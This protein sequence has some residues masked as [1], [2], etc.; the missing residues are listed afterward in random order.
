MNGK[1][2]TAR[3]GREQASARFK[4]KLAEQF[5]SADDD[6]QPGPNVRNEMHR[7]TS[8]KLKPAIEYT[9][10]IIMPSYDNIE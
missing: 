1:V 3:Y 4:R 9:I 7:C 10:Y 6:D 2:N 8:L 5:N